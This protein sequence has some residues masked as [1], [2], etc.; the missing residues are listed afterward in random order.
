[1]HVYLHSICLFVGIVYHVPLHFF[2]IWDF[3]V[4]LEPA[5]CL[6]EALYCDVEVVANEVRVEANAKLVI[7]REHISY[8]VKNDLKN[9]VRCLQDLISKLRITKYPLFH[10]L[11]AYIFKAEHFLRVMV[12]YQRTIHEANRDLEIVLNKD[13]PNQIKVLPFVG[14][15]NSTA[16]AY[17]VVEVIH[18]VLH[19]VSLRSDSSRF[20]FVDIVTT[21]IR[22]GLTID[23]RSY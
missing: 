10:F 20:D 9:A 15:M 14:G 7:F 2:F 5:E 12:R 1:M 19:V 4:A 21:V 18:Y 13:R 8:L 6:G 22:Y 16:L 11:N 23:L 3:R 17:V